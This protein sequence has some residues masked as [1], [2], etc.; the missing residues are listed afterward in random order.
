MTVAVRSSGLG[1][2]AFVLV[3]LAWAASG[4]Y[5]LA[6]QTNGVPDEKT[7]EEALRKKSATP[8]ASPDAAATKKAAGQANASSESPKPAHRGTATPMVVV[9]DVAC[10]LEVNGDSIAVLE[11]GTVKKLS[12]S[13]GDQLVKCASTEEPGEIYSGVQNIKAGE[14]TVLQI[15]LA[16]RLEAVRQKREAQ[17]QSLIAEDELWAQAGQNGTP[18]NLQ[19]YLEK[20]PNGRYVEQANG[21]LAESARRAEEDADWKRAARSTQMAVVQAFIDKYPAGRYL[22]AAQQ[23]IAFVKQIPARPNL[24]FPIEEEAL[25]NSSL[26]MDLPR[27]THKVTVQ[28]SSKVLG[29]PINGSTSAFWNQATTREIVPLSD[30][31]VLLH[32]VKRKSEPTGAPPEV[33]DDYQCGALKLGTVGDGKLIGAVSLSDVEAFLDSDKALRDKPACEI[34]GSGP[35]NAFHPA[36]TGIATRHGCS[37]GDYYFEDL[38]VWLYELGEMDPQKQQYVVPGTGYHFESVA[39][40]GSGGKI[41]TSYEAFSWT[42]SP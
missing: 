37:S 42:D 19:A 22:D 28:I 24:P 8:K 39:D 38:N 5:P 12:V 26:Y 21:L 13:P 25:E 30:K 36:L 18:A 20:Y 1:P 6:A 16:P 35:A 34:P 17:A 2:R 15:V 9:S 27:R 29:E 14:Q 32:T 7:L 41:T 11:P 23:R 3:A 31:C 10:A 4:L 40:G 33:I